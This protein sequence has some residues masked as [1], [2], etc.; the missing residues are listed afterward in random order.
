MLKQRFFSCIVLIPPQL[1]ISNQ[2]TKQTLKPCFNP[3]FHPNARL[4]NRS[5][6]LATPAQ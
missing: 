1:I 6:T 2:S 4:K 3:I 5:Q